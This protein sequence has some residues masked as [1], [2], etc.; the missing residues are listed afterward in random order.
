MGVRPIMSRSLSVTANFVFKLHATLLEAPR[1]AVRLYPV[2]DGAYVVSAAQAPVREFLEDVL[3][4]VADLFVSEDRM[5]HRFIVR[6]ALAYGPA[7]HGHSVPREASWTLDGDSA[8]TASI[9]LGIPV[10]QALESE[11]KAPPFG[12]YVHESA[13]AFAP[14]GEQPLVRVWW[15]WFSPR[16]IELARALRAELKAYFDWCED[17]SQPMEYTKSRIAE[18]REMAE[19]YLADV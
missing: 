2:M 12:V 4:R 5:Q 1:A 10:V 16:W 8:Y 15:P 3:S 7:V 19:Q 6:A 13:R 9:L 18:H 17:R 14:S 11:R